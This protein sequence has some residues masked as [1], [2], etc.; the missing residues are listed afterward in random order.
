VPGS[1]VRNNRGEAAANHRRFEDDDLT[2]IIIIRELTRAGLSVP[3]VQQALE[4]LRAKLAKTP[5]AWC[6]AK[7]FA[8]YIQTVQTLADTFGKADNYD[9]WLTGAQASEHHQEQGNG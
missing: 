9:G 8:A 2:R 5:P 6:S 4:V 3:Q 1:C 7:L